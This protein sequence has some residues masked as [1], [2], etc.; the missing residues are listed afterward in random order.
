MDPT[1]PKDLAD[2]G[3]VLAQYGPTG[4]A[5]CALIV[6][7]VTSYLNSRDRR[8]QSKDSAEAMKDL[9]QKN[10]DSMKLHSDAITAV[11]E[12]NTAA[13]TKS[14]EATAALSASLPH[15]CKYK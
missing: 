3:A 1:N 2:A 12:R 14:A 7:G 10:A 13:L 8:L 11:V 5:I 15:V 4:V 9:A 6:S